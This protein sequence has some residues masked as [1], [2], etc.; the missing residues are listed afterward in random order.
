MQFYKTTV[1]PFTQL[2]LLSWFE[3]H[4][5]ELKPLPWPAQSPGLN[6]IE[7]LCLVL[8][9]RLRNRFLPLTPLKQLEDVLQEQYKIQLETVQDLYESIPRIVIVYV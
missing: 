3:E 8:E 5:S 9:T 1:P 4:K 6:I 7:P 2:E